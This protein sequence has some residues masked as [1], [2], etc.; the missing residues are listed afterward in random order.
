MYILSDATTEDSLYEIASMRGFS[1]LS[2]DRAIPDHTTVMK[3]RNLLEK[4]DLGREYLM[5][6]TSISKSLAC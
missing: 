1:H 4:H 2:L 3:F 6:S 5:L